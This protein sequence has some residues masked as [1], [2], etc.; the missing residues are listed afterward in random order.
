MPEA[1]PLH[2]RTIIRSAKRRRSPAAFSMAMPRRGTGY[3]TA[4]G[5][6]PPQLFDVV[7]RFYRYEATAFWLWFHTRI[8]RGADEFTIDILTEFG[9]IEHTARF[10]PGGLLPVS[11][12]GEVVEYSATLLVRA[13]VVPV[14]APD[15]SGLT[16][17][18]PLTL[19][20]ILRATKRRRQAATFAMQGEEDGYAYAEE[21]GPDVPAIWDIALR[22]TRDDAAL[23]Q[24]WFIDVLE[25][26]VKPFTMPI[27]TEFG[28][29]DHVCQFLPDGLL[30]LEEQGEILTYTASITARALQIPQGYIDAADMIVDTKRWWTW[31]WA[32]DNAFSAT[33]PEA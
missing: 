9:L 17:T 32:L 12:T 27:L 13:Q 11:E 14:D 22:M 7:F 33:L 31:A 16:T 18:Y 26:G 5:T 2:F 28:T 30:S 21:I 10:L 23:L 20:T 6:E 29:V 3:V 1:Y 24:V 4:K 19:P 8:N 25:R 15:S